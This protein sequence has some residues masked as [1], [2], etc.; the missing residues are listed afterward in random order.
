MAP[1]KNYMWSDDGER[2]TNYHDMMKMISEIQM[3]ELPK[4]REQDDTFYGAKCLY[5]N[6]R[7]EER[8]EMV[9]DMDIE[10]DLKQAFPDLICHGWVRRY[11]DTLSY[12]VLGLLVPNVTLESKTSKT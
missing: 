10:I 8:E 7:K 1:A 9:W 11:W 4:V 2:R 6:M 5:A 12:W 3:E